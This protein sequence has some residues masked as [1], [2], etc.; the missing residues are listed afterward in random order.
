LEYVAAVAHMGRVC[1]TVV[2]GLSTTGSASTLSRRLSG[3]SGTCLLGFNPDLVTNPLAFT[4]RGSIINCMISIELN[5]S[6]DYEVYKDFR[7]SNVS[8]ADFGA[9]IKK[10]H[11]SLSQENAK[12]YI[13][14]FYNENK[15]TLEQSRDDLTTA[16]NDKQKEFFGALKSLFGVDFASK[17]YKGYVSIFN[18]NPRFVE[19]S[20]FQVF[21]KRS[22]ADRLSV[23]F[24][25]VLHFA[26]F[27]YCDTKFAER[28][29]G[30]NKNSGIFWEL[31]EVFNVLVLNTL[32]FANILGR[33]EK[34]FYPKLNEKLLQ[35]KIVWG[36]VN[37]DVSKFIEFFL[38]HQQS[39]G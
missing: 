35:A 5:K 30:L 25:E 36:S 27:E 24:H 16:L 14:N 1:E 2:S 13:D 17:S 11:P 19:T 9:L 18:C 32:P 4:A 29:K 26:F 8:G 31:S 12:Q 22:A 34:L 15:E 33:E 39:L 37:G 38:K 7:D 23:V 6:L 10:D 28:L 3:S 20:E 21:Y